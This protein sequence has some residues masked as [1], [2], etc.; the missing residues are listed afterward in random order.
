MIRMRAMKTVVRL[1]K[2]VKKA[3]TAR[4]QKIQ[5]AFLNR[6]QLFKNN[7][8]HP[9]LRNHALTGKYRG[10]RSINITGDWRAFFREE[11]STH[12]TIEITFVLLGTHSQLYK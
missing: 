10:L 2:K 9:Q 6:L 12:D 4:D 3:L 1:D 8:T 5:K 11:K 7:P